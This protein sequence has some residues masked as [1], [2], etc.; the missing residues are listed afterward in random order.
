MMLQL[1]PP[2]P[3]DTPRGKGLAHVLIDYWPEHHLI[4]V[5]IMDATGEIWCWPNPQV[6]GRENP[7]M[8]RN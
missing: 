6:T 8:G 7:T 2:I 4:W 1:D 3:L 5:C